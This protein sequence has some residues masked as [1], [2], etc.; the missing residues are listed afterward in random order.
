M[1][2]NAPVG[3][4]DWREF[5]LNGATPGA[6]HASIVRLAAHLIGK[7]VDARV[8]LELVR[9]WNAQRNSP[10]KPDCEVVAALNFVAGRELAAGRLARTRSGPGPLC[11]RRSAHRAALP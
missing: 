5:V 7:K 9:C 1:P 3:S 4:T 11:A 2:A 10:P 8:A 6:R